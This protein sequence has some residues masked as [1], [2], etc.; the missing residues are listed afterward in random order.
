M[1]AM[2]ADT[3]VNLV[4]ESLKAYIMDN[5]ES[6]RQLNIITGNDPSFFE[7]RNNFDLTIK[8][9][10]EKAANV[11]ISEGEKSAKL[12]LEEISS[13]MALWNLL[14]LEVGR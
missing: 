4:Y 1:L 13:F 9:I 6:L 5:E 2:N 12:L 10:S 14:L 11:F 3:K 7:S 8:R